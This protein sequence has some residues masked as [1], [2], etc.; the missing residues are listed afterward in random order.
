VQA[1]GV[2]SE[3]EPAEHRAAGDRRQRAEREGQPATC[4]ALW[5]VDKAKLIVRE[6]NSRAHAGFVLA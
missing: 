6:Q 1:K 2:E 4:F 3:L 5:R